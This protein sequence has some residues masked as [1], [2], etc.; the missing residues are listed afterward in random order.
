MK[1][2]HFPNIL[3]KPYLLFLI[4]HIH[5]TLRHTIL[6]YRLYQKKQIFQFLTFFPYSNCLHT[7]FHLA[8]IAF[9]IHASFHSWILLHKSHHLQNNIFLIHLFNFQ[10][11]LPHILNYLYTIKFSLY[12]ASFH[13]ENLH[14]KYIICYKSQFHVQKVNFLSIVLHISINLI[15]TCQNH[16]VN[17]FWTL[18]HIIHLLKT[19]FFLNHLPY[20]FSNYL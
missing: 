5:D 11:T 16:V 13:F 20:H 9:H 18:L 15:C 1:K 19:L 7:F 8:I 6:Q 3:L 10:Q 12:H 2:L 17:H 4:Y 14:H